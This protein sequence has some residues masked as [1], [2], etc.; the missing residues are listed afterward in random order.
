MKLINLIQMKKFKTLLFA[1]FFIMT[2]STFAQQATVNDFVASWT[3]SGSDGN[4]YLMTLNDDNT[5]TLKTGSGSIDVVGWK[6]NFND[7]NII[8]D[9]YDH[10][11]MRLISNVSVSSALS[12]N[13]TT[14]SSGVGSGFK[15]YQADVFYD[16][17]T[18]T[19]TM[20]VD[21]SGSSVIL[22]GAT[23]VTITFTK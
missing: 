18:N 22:N 9:K 1:F 23:L 6:L 21:F 7:G 2:G 17:T 16:L 5:A 11:T 19:L 8:Y 14:L 4:T 15:I 20:E 12:V 13:Q 10:T 3:G